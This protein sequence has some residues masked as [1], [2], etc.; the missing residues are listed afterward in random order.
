M[1]VSV[2]SQDSLILRIILFFLGII[3]LFFVSCKQK[4]VPYFKIVEMQEIRRVVR[5]VTYSFSHLGKKP[6]PK[7]QDS[8]IAEIHTMYDLHGTPTAYLVELE[9]EHEKVGY[10]I[11]SAIWTRFPLYTC[12]ESSIY[13]DY[14]KRFIEQIVSKLNGN[15][16]YH[17]DSKTNMRLIY[18]GGLTPYVE[19]VS[20]GGNTYYFDLLQI[21]QVAMKSLLTMQTIYEKCGMNARAKTEKIKQSWQYWF[22]LS[23]KG[24]KK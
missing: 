24:E 19:L 3:L 10:I 8:Q 21:Q 7:W 22:N 11:V 14:K 1:S 4:N 15:L 9:K 17:S 18:F 2:K 12:S 13:M 16:N 5:G 23:E 20:E 6:F